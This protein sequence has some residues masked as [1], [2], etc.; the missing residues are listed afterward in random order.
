MVSTQNIWYYFWFDHFEML[1]WFSRV[2]IYSSLL[3]Y[4]CIIDHLSGMLITHK[5]FKHTPKEWIY[6]N[7]GIMKY[8]WIFFKP[9]LNNME[10]IIKSLVTLIIILWILI[11]FGVNSFIVNITVFLLF[12]IWLGISLSIFESD[13]KYYCVL[14]LLF[15]MCFNTTNQN[16]GFSTKLS[17]IFLVYTLFAGGISKMLHHFNG[18]SLYYFIFCRGSQR[19]P[20][21]KFIYNFLKNK[22][23]LFS[24][25]CWFTIVF[26]LLSII[27]IFP[28]RF[29]NTIY[30]RFLWVLPFILFHCI[31]RM[32]M[33]PNYIPQ[34]ISY[35]VFITN[36]FGTNNTTDDII[37]T[38]ND[39]YIAIGNCI[40][41]ILILVIVFRIEWYP[42]TVI[43]MYSYDRSFL[44]EQHPN[45]LNKNVFR[46]LTEQKTYLY[47]GY[48]PVYHWNAEWFKF[49]LIMY[50][51][52]DIDKIYNLI[53]WINWFSYLNKKKNQYFQRGLARRRLFDCVFSLKSDLLSCLV[54]DKDKYLTIYNRKECYNKHNKYFD[55]EQYKNVQ[56]YVF[57]LISLLKK[58]NI[59][60]LKSS[61][62]LRI[63]FVENEEYWNDRK[64]HN[65]ICR[66]SFGIDDKLYKQKYKR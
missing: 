63:G 16:N 52:N 28:N 45:V 4:M 55:D 38:N 19:Q 60:D 36:I 12:L 10:I 40:L 32:V 27:C 35:F 34:S 33:Y 3:Y 61:Y 17:S 46:K 31:I 6:F 18:Y 51:N 50:K 24:L 20:R 56:C 47:P 48:D 57:G 43:P 26:Q 29:T 59:I 15:A 44:S 13:H 53:E 21:N 62:Q 49:E 54:K 25:L 8:V 1:D 2:L 42:F 37:N 65:E 66:K 14:Y 30:K 9:F 41:L 22:K 5:R 23:H 7:H 39:W 58:C 11:I 64:K